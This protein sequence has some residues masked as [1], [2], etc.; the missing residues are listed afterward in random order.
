MVNSNFTF[1]SKL[2]SLAASFRETRIRETRS[3]APTARLVNRLSFG[4][5]VFVGVCGA[6]DAP[7]DKLAD[8]NTADSSTDGD[9]S[10]LSVEFDLR[11]GNFDQRQQAM[12]RLWADHDTYRTWV[13]NAV[14]DPD[15]EVARRANWVL[16]RWRRGLLPDTPREISH[17]LEGLHGPET[18]ENL[19]NAGLFRAALVAIDEVINAA[20][21]PAIIARAESAILR[22]FA[23]YVRLA[24]ENDQLPALVSILD[25]LSNDAPMCFAASRLRTLTTNV[26]HGD[27]LGVAARLGESQRK[28]IE[29]ILQVAA[30][31]IPKA[32]AL[33]ENFDDPELLRVCRML[34]GDWQILAREQFVAARSQPQD[35]VD[36]YRHWMYALVAASRCDDL[37]IR[38]KAIEELSKSRGEEHDADAKDPVNRIRWQSL[39]MHGEIDAAIAVLRLLKSKD[40][41]EPTAQAEL[42]AQAELLA[43]ASR[44]PD[45]FKAIGIDWVD[46]DSQMNELIDDAVAAERGNLGIGNLEPSVPLLRLL[47]AVRLLVS[48]GRDDLALHSLKA[49]VDHPSLRSREETSMIRMEL[50][51]TVWRISRTE[52]IDELIVGSRDKSLPGQTQF[53]LSLIYDAEV[54]SIAALIDALSQLNS[55]TTFAQ[56][57]RDTVSILGGSLPQWFDPGTDFD[58]LYDR[59]L[60]SKSVT[61]DAG[62]GGMRLTS[63]PLL[64]IDIAR[65]FELHGQTELSQKTL[66]E[67]SARGDVEATLRLAESEL[68]GGN[69]EVARRLFRSI[70][71]SV[72]VAGQDI[73]RL[74]QADSDALIALKAIDGEATAATRLGD[75][76]GAA[77]LR[78]QIAMMICTPSST[79]LNSYA[80]YLT[81]QGRNDQAKEILEPLM[82]LAAFGLTEGVEFYTIAHNYDSAVAVTNPAQA[83]AALDLAIAGTIE[84]TSFYPA[85]YISVPSYMYRRKIRAAVDS[86]NE[87]EARKLIEKLLQLDPIDIDF[88]EKLLGAMRDAGMTSLASEV[89]ERMYQAGEKHLQNFPF[90]VAMSNNLAWVLS[91]SDYRLD[92]ALRISKNAV[93]YKP[94]STIYRDTLAEVLFRL[95]RIDEAIAIEKACLLDDPSEW[96]VHEQI[97]RFESAKST[98]H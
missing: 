52:W 97:Q 65:I 87:P 23:F 8:I 43:Q 46:L 18:I 80:E 70:W 98:E 7:G 47:S 44:F 30:A 77:E 13:E 19:L 79:L 27:L 26:N 94:D 50:V 29:I 95:K 54:E 36:W 63:V 74:N 53:L 1:G 72:D 67:L 6:S 41:A 4:V 75:V 15:I 64:S 83:A 20:K 59:L 57:V 89:L 76:E 22:R 2:K 38:K 9:A 32:T 25:R 49:V 16:D 73:S 69:V 68:N 58:K 96:H 5:L 45:A 60:N 24:D 88:G 84:S 39:A 61:R 51:R 48:T 35:S 66:V 37:L 33:A 92:D 34:G 56:R 91:L 86:R 93:F 62:G 40:L 42:K 12:M 3:A 85:A 78:R 55:A 14:H 31:D 81:E 28:R 82:S 17:R 71:N 11:S 10:L 90:D 21:S